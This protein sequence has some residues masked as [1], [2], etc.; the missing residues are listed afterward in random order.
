[1]SAAFSLSNSVA[2]GAFFWAFNGVGLALLIPNAQSLIAYYYKPVSRGA[3]FGALYLPGALG[4][5]AGGLFATN[6]GHVRPFGVE[7]WR[8]AFLSVAA[9]SAVVG[10]L[11]LVYSVDP[12]YKIEEPQYAQDPDIFKERPISMSRM[13]ADVGSV[14]AVPSF[15]LIVVQGIIGYVFINKMNLLKV[16]VS[17]LLHFLGWQKSNLFNGAA[18]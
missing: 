11:N 10:A 15:V 16:V 6:I 2:S 17:Y 8:I 3:A 12:R 14:L 4:G 13:A 7:G 5:M 18:T 1:M 9:L